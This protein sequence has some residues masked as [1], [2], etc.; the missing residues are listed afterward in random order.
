MKY[1][2]LLLLSAALSLAPCLQA[3]PVLT[4]FQA[5]NHTTLAD[6]LVQYPD[7]IEI[8]NPDETPVSLAGWRLSNDSAVSD[9][10]IFPALT[11]DPGQAVVV[12][13][14]GRDIRTG[15]VLHTNFTLDGGGGFLGLFT[16]E[17]TCVSC[18][19]A[20][21]RQFSGISYG[22]GPAN[23][24]GY[25]KVP[26][27][28]SLND[29]PL[30][31]YVRDTKFSVERGFFTAP[32]QVTVTT[33]T[34]GAQI[35]Y[36]TD[37]TIPA[38]DSPLLPVP[39]TVNT[40]TVLRVRAFHPELLASNTD[41]QTYI[42]PE[43]WRTQPDLPPG[44]SATWGNYDSVAK[45]LGDYG[46]ETTV[47]NNATYAGLVV[48]AMTQTLP[49]VC[50]TGTADDIFGDNGVQGNLRKTGSEVPV[51]VEYFNPLAPG[52]TWT[53][54]ATVQAH[55]A[56]VR[57]FPK[58]A[59]RID[60]SGPEAD[61]P[62]RYPLFPGSASEVH[63]QLVLRGC[64]HDS[65]TARAR[66]G[67]PDANDL[68]FHGSYIRDQ[69]LRATESAAGLLSP[70]GRY[71]HL[72]LN[73]LYWGV[74]DLHERPNATF[75]STHAGGAEPEWDV[76]HHGP[77][78]LEG[79]DE[80]W[81]ELQALASVG[82]TSQA[83]YDALSALVGPDA[84]I[85]HM[86]IRMW[87]ADHDW[88]GPVT[89]PSSSIGTTG[90]VAIY[91]T[92]NWY[93]ARNSRAGGV[94]PWHFFTWDG[95]ISMGSHLLF[96]WYSRT[97]PD[98][99]DFPHLRE[100]QLDM[101][102]ISASNT[103][104]AVW[105]ALRAWPEFRTR[106]GDRA[107]RMFGPG[108]ALSPATA[109][110]RIEALRNQL[111]LAIVAES[112]RWG[113]AS[114]FYFASTP[115]GIRQYW[116]GGI[117]DPANKAAYQLTRDTHWRPEIEWLRDTWTTQRTAIFLNQLAARGLYPAT[118]PVDIAPFGGALTQGQDITLTGPAGAQ[119]R[120]T[121]DG[122]DP[123][124]G[125]AG[126]FTWPAK[127]AWPAG[128]FTLQ[129]RA[130]VSGTSE[131]S[132]LTQATF[133][134]AVPPLPGDLVLTE[135][136]YHPADPTAAEIMEGFT[137]A[138]QFEF[139]EIANLS[140]RRLNLSG[141]HFAAGINFSFAGAAITELA[142]GGVLL[143]V[144][145][146]AAFQQRYGAGH[147]VAGAFTGTN[148]S[149]SGERLKLV[150][151]AGATILEVN[152]GDSGDWPAA[153]DGGGKSLTLLDPAGGNGMHGDA[154]RPSTQTGGTPGAL[155]VALTFAEWQSDHFSPAQ[156]ADP[157]IS[158][159]LADP[160]GDG[161]ANML[162]YAAVKNPLAFSKPPVAVVSL[163]D[164]TVQFSWER[165]RH[166]VEI[167]PASAQLQLWSG[168]GPWL[169]ADAAGAGVTQTSVPTGQG[170]D[171]VTVTV[172]RSLSAMRFARVRAAF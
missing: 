97:V 69:F 27:P 153:A 116:D 61:G 126:V 91:Q 103:P 85:D 78:V 72:C 141:L 44:V 47:T 104:A 59:F 76:M 64:G 146:A 53:T 129:A 42:F 51:S 11:L 81:S 13:A 138:D 35:R 21:P 163:P 150:D 139:L 124:G 114:G 41:T 25:F 155:P 70:R 136:H 90:N 98:G 77:Q 48:P 9:K 106:V 152:Y 111:D 89:M 105:D 135:I 131:W 159:P 108:G 96:L 127:P 142:P 7:W 101:T 112:A 100:L 8:T 73:G 24:T 92:K 20:Y 160:D 93:A 165:R 134:T 123:Q 52:E 95:E 158:G 169:N 79:T 118:A 46:M 71:V 10:W 33:S 15:A 121:I 58:K 140:P 1:L 43:T 107:R 119:L 19:A 157:D 147:P 31:D 4:E 87:A 143:L 110:A 168:T 117:A 144:S 18:F 88:L 167:T 115:A 171:L 84:F 29:V 86:L 80:K 120:Y 39:F 37:K 26:S 130:F 16:P 154:W 66:G 67:K 14:S 6:E 145:D 122:T 133:T 156:L 55:G 23:E 170:T 102:G 151:A 17:G 40:T 34:P 5:I 99:L 172:S 32:F 125:G 28:G 30:A 166:A 65:F 54:R 162:E 128:T 38:E 63:D 12:F 82:V 49:V 50:V 148:L 74:Y 137:D 68:A 164:G 56:A 75:F 109:A 161:L 2:P 83:E 62:L 36:T 132:A 149:N 3:A 113:R 45:V 57:D 22:R 60:F 94:Q